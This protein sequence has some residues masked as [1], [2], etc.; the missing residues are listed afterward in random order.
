MSFSVILKESSPIIFFVQKNVLNDRILSSIS[1]IKLLRWYYIVRSFC[2][3]RFQRRRIIFTRFYSLRFTIFG[4]S[5]DL[6]FAVFVIKNRSTSHHRSDTKSLNKN[7][8][9]RTP[10]NTHSDYPSFLSCSRV[11]DDLSSWFIDSST[12]FLKYTWWLNEE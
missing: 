3:L 6:S 7:R 2:I 10:N 4:E 11:N 9:M 12:L 5:L 1:V 8:K